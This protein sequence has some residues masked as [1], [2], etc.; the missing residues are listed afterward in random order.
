MITNTV[1]T[2]VFKIKSTKLNLAAL[3][4]IM[5]GGSPISVAVP[6]I[7]EAMICVMIYG[8]GSTFKIFVIARV[9]GPTSK[10]VVTLSSIPD[11]NKDHH[12][13]P[14]TTFC[15]FCSFDRYVFENTRILDNSNQKHHSD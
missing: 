5:L 3:P 12:D 4:I 1:A 13:W 6:P 14:W 11:Q 10:T 8:T 7:L 15:D 9:I 2:P